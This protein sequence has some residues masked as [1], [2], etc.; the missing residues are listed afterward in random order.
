[1]NFRLAC[2]QVVLSETAQIWREA[3]DFFPVFFLDLNVPFGFASRINDDIG[4]TKLTVS[5]L[6]NKHLIRN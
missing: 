4:E 3:N 2:D 6:T 1:M 5:P